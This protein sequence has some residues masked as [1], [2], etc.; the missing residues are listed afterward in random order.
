MLVK[1]KLFY[2]IIKL[3][4]IRS[5]HNGLQ[6]IEVAKGIR[7]ICHTG[8]LTKPIFFFVNFILTMLWDFTYL[9]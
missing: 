3:S 5:F 4:N 2:K 9:Y 1:L 8:P 7:P 6:S